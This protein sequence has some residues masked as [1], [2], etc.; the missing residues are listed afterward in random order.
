MNS[1]AAAWLLLAVLGTD[2]G[3][4][5]SITVDD[6]IEYYRIEGRTARELVAQMELLGPVGSVTGR[7]AAGYTESEVAW[8]HSH[9]MREGA[10]R[11]NY[12]DV[13]VTIVIT[14]P[15][16][17]RPTR[18][19]PA[20]AAQWK[21][22]MANLREHEATH[23]QHG[24]QAAAAVRQAILAMPP[25]ADC[26]SLERAIGKAAR[27]E[28]R[29]YAAEGRKY[30]ALTEFGAKQGVRLNLE[31]LSPAMRSRSLKVRHRATL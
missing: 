9:E 8:E 15:E 24:L 30:D 6:R 17:V 29:R 13:S 11:L 2:G 25:H 22:F 31:P 26:R 20:L 18:E 27:Q 5:E 23:R 4:P 7:R 16:W 3:P 19:R 10:C 14:L 28:M 21:G 12:L 1:I